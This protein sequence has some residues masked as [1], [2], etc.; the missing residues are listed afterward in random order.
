[1]TITPYTRQA[2]FTDHSEN[3]PD[4]PHDGTDLDAEFNALKTTIDSLIE[5]LNN[6]SRADGKIA[7]GAV[8]P[9]SLSSGLTVGVEPATTWVTATAYTASTDL[10]WQ[11][12][13]LYQCLVS[14]TSG[15]FATDLAAGRWLKIFDL[16]SE[17]A[18]VSG[19]F[20]SQVQTITGTKNLTEAD[21]G[22]I[23]LADTSSAAVTV[24]LPD[25]TNLTDPDFFRCRIV[26]LSAS[27]AL[28]VGR[29]S[30]SD[31]IAGIGTSNKTFPA[32]ANLNVDVFATGS[33]EDYHVLAYN[34]PNDDSVGTDQLQDDCVTE[35]KVGD[36]Q[37]TAPKLADVSVT[38]RT[39]DPAQAAD[40]APSSGTVT[41]DMTANRYQKITAAGAFTFDVTPPDDGAGNFVPGTAIVE[42][43]NWGSLNSGAGPTMTGID[44]TADGAALAF[45]T[46]GTD[47]LSLTADDAGEVTAFIAIRN[48]DDLP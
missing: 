35:D 2:N 39:V 42:C 25:S 45:T 14:H 22:I 40:T 26:A 37:I 18:A 30:S 16:L 31:T 19:L 28:T 44:K 47:F 15:N 38:P 11:N 5:R 20:G 23:F 46:S 36:E 6:I 48:V 9:A 34:E 3:N 7:N 12:G 43:V 21:N 10:V 8:V 17:T 32:R 1:M 41:F 4:L 29:Q 33:G 13:A 27:N 24:R